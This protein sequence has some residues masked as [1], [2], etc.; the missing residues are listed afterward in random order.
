MICMQHRNLDKEIMAEKA[1]SNPSESFAKYTLRNL[2]SKVQNEK[3]KMKKTVDVKFLE[4]LIG[5]DPLEFDRNLLL[6]KENVVKICERR[7][8]LFSRIH[9]IAVYGDSPT[10]LFD[11]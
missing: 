6:E 1:D 8:G 11:W 2:R 7:F 5:E 10:T 4:G 3:K 9:A